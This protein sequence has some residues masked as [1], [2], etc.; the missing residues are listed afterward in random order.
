MIIYPNVYDGFS[1]NTAK[2]GAVDSLV[3]FEDVVVLARL[4]NFCAQPYYVRG[5]RLVS[6]ASCDFLQHPPSHSPRSQNMSDS[7]KIHTLLPPLGCSSVLSDFLP[8][9]AEITVQ[10]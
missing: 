2:N 5:R 8:R 1:I 7:A 9:S 10:I 3:S 6:T 4:H